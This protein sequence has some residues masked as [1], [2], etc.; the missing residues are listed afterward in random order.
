VTNMDVI[1]YYLHYRQKNAPHGSLVAGRC[2]GQEEPA[3]SASH[4]ASAEYEP[5]GVSKVEGRKISSCP[6][7]QAKASAS[8]PA[9][10]HL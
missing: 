8:S 10:L 6:W 7:D 9:Y 2:A 4:G 3:G 1:I 5:L